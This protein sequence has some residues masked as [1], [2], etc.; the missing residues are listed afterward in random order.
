MKPGN[1]QRLTLEMC[2]FLQCELRD[3]RGEGSL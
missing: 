1:S 2:Q 3:K